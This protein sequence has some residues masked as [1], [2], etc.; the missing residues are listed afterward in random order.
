MSSLN[1]RLSRCLLLVLLAVFYGRDGYGSPPKTWPGSLPPGKWLDQLS[2]IYVA[3]C[4]WDTDFFNEV[5]S[6]ITE[7]RS[8]G[9]MPS[10]PK[11]LTGATQMV[12]CTK[13]KRVGGRSEGYDNGNSIITWYPKDDAS[14]V[15]LDPGSPCRADRRATLVHEF[16]HACNNAQGKQNLTP[17]DPKKGKGF[18]SWDELDAV[19]NENN[20]RRDKDCC[21]RTRYGKEDLDRF[22]KDHGLD[23]VRRPEDRPDPRDPYRSCSGKLVPNCVGEVRYDRFSHYINANY[24]VPYPNMCIHES[25]TGLGCEDRVINDDK[26]GT[27]G[28]HCF[29]YS[30]KKK[31]DKGNEHLLKE[32]NKYPDLIACECGQMACPSSKNNL[33]CINAWSDSQNCGACGRKADRCLGGQTF[34][35]EDYKKKLADSQKCKK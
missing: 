3:D 19:R 31:Y 22:A 25:L 1:R 10:C 27:P 15:V 29:S 21:L 8:N 23:P 13:D 2:G 33:R 6:A 24:Y 26:G 14:D 16:T 20:F 30:D 34:S 5:Q 9:S 11:L 12:T 35:N 18:G 32:P 7:A 4:K 17:L 28:L